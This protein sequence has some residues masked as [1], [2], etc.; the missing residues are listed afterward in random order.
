MFGKVRQNTPIL[1]TPESRAAGGKT[2]KIFETWSSRC[3]SKTKTTKATGYHD[4]DFAQLG[5]DE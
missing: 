1:K 4:V 3:N 5:A 2:P